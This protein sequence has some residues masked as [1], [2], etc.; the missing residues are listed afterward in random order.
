M[1]ARIGL[2]AAVSLATVVLVECLLRIVPPKVASAWHLGTKR[3][4]LDDELIFIN[5]RHT[6]ASFYRTDP[7]LPTVVTLGDSFTEGYPVLPSRSYPSCLARMLARSGRPANVINLGMGD[8]SPDQ[9]LR[10]FKRYALEHV[11]PNV[12]V[13]QLYE[14]D[15]W[16]NVAR[17]VYT[18]D[19][20]GRLQP[21]SG[22]D[23]WLYKRQLFYD[24]TPARHR[25]KRYSYIYQYLLKSA[26]RWGTAQV[27]AEYASDP[28][29]WG[30]D[31]LR[32]EIAEMDRLGDEHGFRVYYVVVPP[33]AMYMHDAAGDDGER[34]RNL[35]ANHP[36]LRAMMEAHKG[37]IDLDF[38]N[39][40][41]NPAWLRFYVGGRRDPSGLGRLHLNEAGYRSMA[42]QVS[43]H[44]LA[45]RVGPPEQTRH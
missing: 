35:K 38:A 37:Y 4:V 5:P 36:K 1:L 10:L 9:Q 24:A 16:D 33:Q 8:S 41:A 17:P 19:G 43:R 28:E 14:N 39:K 21:L 31:K 34:I 25:L 20:S 26:E 22:A 15:V 12:V 13:W 2:A 44:I 30:R 42:R 3:R 40:G 18:I 29:R 45:R 32:L 23:N 27:P 7:H 11:R 6:E